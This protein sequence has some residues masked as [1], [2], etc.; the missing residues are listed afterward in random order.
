MAVFGPE[1]KSFA[2]GILCGNREP[3]GDDVVI[4]PDPVG[5]FIGMKD[6]EHPGKTVD[7]APVGEVP[8]F[9]TGI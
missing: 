2:H 6:T 3:A 5:G 1:E 9:I 7:D 4:P 8:H